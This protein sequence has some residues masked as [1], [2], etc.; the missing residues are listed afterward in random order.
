MIDFSKLSFGDPVYRIIERLNSFSRNKIVTVIDGVEWYRYDKPVRSYMIVQFTYVGRAYPVIE[1]KVIPEDIDDPMFFVENE[2]GGVAY[3]HDR[4]VDDSD[5]FSS[6]DE[7]EAEMKFR[8]EE[9]AE[10]DRR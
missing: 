8:Q 1:G 2:D 10:I 9:Q 4:D 5:W 3:L 6:K 7:A